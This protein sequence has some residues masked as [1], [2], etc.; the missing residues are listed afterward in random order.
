MMHVI[1]AI[2]AENLKIRAG[3]P[4]PPQSAPPSDAEDSDHDDTDQQS[5]GAH[6]SSR[7]HHHHH[8]RMSNHSTTAEGSSKP[9][10]QQDTAHSDSTTSP[11][12]QIVSCPPL[13]YPDQASL[14]RFSRR[15]RELRKLIDLDISSTVLLDMDPLTEYE[16]YVRSCG[17]SSTSQAA[18]QCGDDRLT[19]EVQTEYIS[20]TSHWTQHPPEDLVGSGPRCARTIST[21]LVL[22]PGHSSTAAASS[23]SGA[24]ELALFAIP[25]PSGSQEDTTYR[26]NLFEKPRRPSSD[27]TDDDSDMDASEEHAQAD[28]D[29]GF[30][31]IVDVPRFA[32]FMRSAVHVCDT[33]LGER[34]TLGSSGFWSEESP[35][36]RHSSRRQ[37]ASQGARPVATRA[38][39]TM[40]A[41]FLVGRTMTACAWDKTT[42]SL[43]LIAHGRAQ[44]NEQ[45]RSRDRSSSATASHSYTSAQTLRSK[46][47]LTV[48]DIHN[49]S[50]PSFIL[51]CEGTATACAFSPAKPDLVV[52]GSDEGALWVW[53][54]S[55]AGIASRDAKAV[56]RI[57]VADAPVPVVSP[58][59]STASVLSAH[60]M[61]VCAL[62]TLPTLRQQQLQQLAHQAAHS[63]DRR[64][65]AA[66][67]QSMASTSVVSPGPSGPSSMALAGSAPQ[68]STSSGAKASSTASTSS[69]SSSSL[70]IDRQGEFSLASQSADTFDLVSVDQSGTVC[71]WV[72]VP[73]AN[74][75][76][77]SGDAAASPNMTADAPAN[78]SRLAAAAESD[79]ALAPGARVRLV[80]TGT[81]KAA[82][83]Q[84]EQLAGGAEAFCLASPWDD[85][86]RIYVGLGTYICHETR[87]GR[88]PA[89]RVFRPDVGLS[90]LGSSLSTV[91]SVTC[92][93]LVQCLVVSPLHATYFLAGFADGSVALF[94]RQDERALLSW[95]PSARPI[96]HVFWSARCVSAVSEPPY[97][98]GSHCA[99]HVYVAAEVR[100]FSSLLMIVDGSFRGTSD[101]ACSIR[102]LMI[103]SCSHQRPIV[104]GISLTSV[105]SLSVAVVVHATV[106]AACRS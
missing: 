26:R 11:F 47:I 73:T 32:K 76:A 71:V 28:T 45:A 78:S 95:A 13:P 59:F 82:P 35:V 106:V 85:V 22:G 66:F 46:G 83:G 51:V 40:S 100:R 57:T 4:T 74:I 8:Q 24:S 65:S 36:D 30:A 49:P 61:P 43:L 103:Q 6:K 27:D 25:I 70:R 88:P 75:G 34:M 91:R 84:T 97:F 64:S 53:D 72:L 9:R 86:S 12:F 90:G 63:T 19:T 96:V 18:T 44:G 60:S 87:L 56:G 93:R 10:R 92:G 3:K 7:S 17:Q 15:G 54:L 104:R 68:A 21:S 67:F 81:I 41:P 50:R 42:G 37:S 102:R 48:W 98:W 99:D 52:A 20:C 105:S 69:L 77:S 80:L 39:L 58:V 101:R 14:A 94:S 16:L 29:G 1:R 38:S 23:D 5:N 33:L 55:A 62:C 31:A 89:P 2:G 79:L